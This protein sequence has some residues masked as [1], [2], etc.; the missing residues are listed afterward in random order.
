[1]E[2]KRYYWLKLKDN[3]FNDKRIKRLRQ[4]AGGDTF[5]IIYL[6]M[7]LKA[8]NT[9]GFLYFD[10]VLGNFYEELAL[11]L[12][13]SPDNVQLTIE[14]LLKVGLLEC[15]PDGTQYFLPELSML[16]GSE[17]A[18]TQRVRDYRQRKKEEQKALQCN[19]NETET[20]QC[21]AN[22]TKLL[23]CNTDVTEVKRECSVEKEKEKDI[24]ID[25]R[26][27][28]KRKSAAAFS[29]P[30][31]EEVQA[32]CY[33]RHNSIDPQSFIDFYMSKN[34]YVGKNKM[35]D[36]K[37][38]VRTWEHR[39]NDRQGSRPPNAFN[40]G[41]HGKEINFIQLEEQLLDN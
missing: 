6:K 14:Y 30:S 15:D 39:D 18:S 28:I 20:L 34:W 8:L 5:T 4:L 1:M 11:D 26:E 38:A 21:N 31:L 40:S 16:I 33:E 12:D 29:P 25:K 9:D 13:E 32:Y 22:E 3:F 10:N 35:K 41:M 37:A 2:G 36:W 7:Q 24:D 27:S 19:T 17:S 23:Q